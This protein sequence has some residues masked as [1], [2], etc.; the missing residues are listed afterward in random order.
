M[1]RRVIA[2]LCHDSVE[3]IPTSSHSRNALVSS[4]LTEPL[5]VSR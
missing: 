2:D 3:R 4:L 5:G 1:V